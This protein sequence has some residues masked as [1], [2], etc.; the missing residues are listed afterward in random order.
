MKMIESI[1]S[2]KPVRETAMPKKAKK[3]P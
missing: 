3:N 2:K 1:K